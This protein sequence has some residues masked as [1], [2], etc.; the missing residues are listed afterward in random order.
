MVADDRADDASPPAPGA[1]V[2]AP[3]SRPGPP[4]EGATGR[5]AWLEALLAPWTQ[6]TW[7]ADAR[8]MVVAD[9]PSWRA[10]TGQTAE[11]RRGEGWTLAVH[12]DER[13]YVLTA[14]RE[15]VRK[16]TVADLELRLQHAGG[17]RWSNLR[18]APVRDAAGAVERWLALH[19]DVS[20][21]R[22]AEEVEHGA[23]E[24]NA[25]LV[26]LSD[27][28][29]SES[30]PD[31]VRDR[32]LRV[33]G[34]HLGASQVVHAEVLA[35]GETV[36]LWAPY[37]RIGAP[38]V[39]GRHRLADLGP[40]AVATVR[41]GATLVVD[42][43]T[44]RTPGERAGWAS[45]GAAAHVA[46]PQRREGRLV[47]LLVA[48]QTPPPEWTA[49]HVRLLEEAAVR[50]WEALDRARA[51][52]ERARAREELERRVVERT[53][54]LARANAQLRAEARE[55]GRAEQARTGLQ[56][57]LATAQEDERRRIARDLHDQT[58]QLLASLSLAV[59]AVAGADALPPP[60]AGRLAE[61]QRVADELG[62]QVHE[63][64][65]R[66]RPT[67]LDDLGLS[68]ALRELV[69][70]WSA[71]TG[72]P[73]D[74]QTV[75]LDVGRLP[76]EVETVLYRV[77]QEALTNVAKHASACQVSVVVHRLEG[78]ATVVIEDDGRGFD[79]AQ[80]G[81][82][83]LGLRG[84]RERVTQLGGR[85]DIDAAPGTGTSLIVRLSDHPTTLHPPAPGAGDEP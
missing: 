23:A 34:E 11:E 19:I 74:L 47:R 58:G 62:R 29:R 5:D 24:R 3:G 33:L 83:R 37:V 69:D 53:S 32:A 31:A 52:Q 40:R 85:L 12:P 1:P 10:Y 45:L 15:A 30:G 76:A 51:E 64:A 54:E 6:A 41:A 7:E 38:T 2:R 48:Y 77:V 49:R 25:F 59:Q 43:D 9:S 20:E 21:R 44:P 14:W 61:V 68:A 84:M 70:G 78:H 75:G 65:V 36:E 56:R 79:P 13:A 60:V 50:I 4:G 16:G 17:W 66:L 72:V 22:R 39:A 8:G 26:T 81:R 46:V 35:D 73:V 28:L 18:A 71:R 42:Q 82:D 80:I 55:R 27:A 57:Q 67:T 63:L